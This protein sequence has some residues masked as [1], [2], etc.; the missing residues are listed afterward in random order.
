MRAGWRWLSALAAAA[1]LAG[2]AGARDCPAPAPADRSFGLAVLRRPQTPADRLPRALSPAGSQPRSTRLLGSLDERR[3]YLVAV[4]AHVP[5]SR[6][7]RTI[8]LIA[9][10]VPRAT[11]ATSIGGATTAAEIRAGHV[12][13]T[14]S[15]RTATGAYATWIAGLVPDGVAGVTVRIRSG[16]RRT[17]AMASNFF[18]VAFSGRGDPRD[19]LVATVTWRDAHGR[20]VKVVRYP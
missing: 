2:C 16:Q 15:T 11:R 18:A 13:G 19:P 8:V 5:R 12:G 3:F 10:L 9:E 20:V 17:L 7:P 14:S 6:C 1:A 4:D